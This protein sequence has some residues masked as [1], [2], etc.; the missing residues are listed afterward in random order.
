M[1]SRGVL[2]TGVVVLAGCASNPILIT[3]EQDCEVTHINNSHGHQEFKRCAS[4]TVIDRSKT[5]KELD[6][7][8]NERGNV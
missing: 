4:S 6:L 8:L 5:E 1:F 2:L 3:T 7:T